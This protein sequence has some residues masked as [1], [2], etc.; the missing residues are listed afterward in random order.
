MFSRTT[1]V[2]A[3]LVLAATLSLSLV[4]SPSVASAQRH[5]LG[6][7][8][9]SFDRSV[10]PQDD[11]FRFVNGGWLKK[12][13]IPDDA[14]S[15][16]TFDELDE[17]SRESMHTV[18]EEAARAN[19]PAG[20][21]QRKV[22]DLYASFMDSARVES[23][24]L[25]PLKGELATI[26]AITS[27]S[28]LP[29]A[30]AHFARVGI[31]RPLGVAVG[32]DQK[33]SSVNIVQIGQAGLGLP[34][35]DYYLMQDARMVAV[36][37]AYLGYA[38]R[39][40]T[41]A[42]Q[43]DPAGAAARVLALE[44]A[45][46][47]KQ[48]DRARNRDRN[49][50]YNRMSV[51][52]LAAQMPHFDWKAH[53]AAAGLGAATEVVVRQPDY[54]VATDSILAATPVS[55]WREYLTFKLLDSFAPELPASFVNARFDF[56]GKVLSG[57]QAN[58]V[59]WKRGVAEVGGGLGEAAG[60]L[61]IARNFKPEAKARMDALVRNL[62]EAYRIGID[63]LEWMAPETKAQAKEK[64][65]QFTVKIAYPDKWRDYTRLEIRRGDL[66]GN[67]LRARDYEFQDMLD[68]LGKPVDRTRW[69]MTP[70][71]VNAYYNPTNNEIVFPAAIL[72]PPFFDPDADD[73]VNYG[74]IGA[75]I[76]H[77][78]GH[79]FDDQGR[80][81]DGAGN[82]RDWWTAADAKAFDERATRLGAQYDVLSP[83][84]GAHV[85]GKLTMGENIGDLSGLA[86]A[87][88]AYRISLGGKEAPVIGGFT[89]D[90]R[91][92]LGFAQIWRSNAREASL[93]QQ[94]LSDPHSPAQYRVFVPLTNSDAFQ[95]AFDVKPGDKMYR[96]PAERV[97]IW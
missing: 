94:L 10:R 15:W 36:R 95:R 16:G 81:S 26:A 39:L 62:R 58:R 85:N 50:T 34:D 96:S 13:T 5:A 87:Y 43:P 30:F 84:E 31:P 91:F 32:P 65:A 22:G 19:A 11:F 23:V 45:L 7:D 20:S 51:A 37:Q 93:R 44:T 24:G 56:R 66:L 67:T 17:R 12:T 76:G 61:Y 78:I 53:L 47:A 40:F 88:R 73:A 48:W 83:F 60:K 68:Q 14:S 8:T 4:L 52:E 1:A 9:T 18:L 89:G 72:Q 63:S 54:L 55:T 57:L 79:G 38:N 97:H 2:I 82:L 6:V 25:A 70:Q 80:K 74:A 29:A 71:T 59:R 75:V 92:F 41:L 35:R 3:R 21:E 33:H 28:Q 42:E 64:L 69:S 46:A 86:Q 49:A 77:E 90:Q 27:P